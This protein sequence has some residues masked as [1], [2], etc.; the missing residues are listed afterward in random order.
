MGYPSYSAYLQSDH[1]ADVRSRFR[2]SKLK[3]RCHVCR[4]PYSDLHHRT[5]KRL[6]K[7]RLTDLVPLCRDCHGE[8]HQ[9]AKANANGNAGFALWEAA[10]KARREHKRR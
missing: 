10:R 3:K 8:V 9:W 2:K 4:G 5:Y 1:W 6:G 7:E